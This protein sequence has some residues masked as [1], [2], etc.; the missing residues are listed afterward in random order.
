VLG[1][2]EAHG[3]PDANPQHRSVLVVQRDKTYPGEVPTLHGGAVSG[4]KASQA[5]VR[6]AA[7]SRQVVRFRGMADI[8]ATAE[9]ETCQNPTSLK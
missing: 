3:E 7:H 1:Q 5:L 8:Q 6:G 2:L 9:G 4:P